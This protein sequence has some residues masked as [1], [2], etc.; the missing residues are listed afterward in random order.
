MGARKFS[1]VTECFSKF[2]TRFHLNKKNKR[3]IN[4]AFSDGFTVVNFAFIL[5]PLLLQQTRLAFTLHGKMRKA[6][7]HKF[8]TLAVLEPPRGPLDLP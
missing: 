1:K 2:M 4:H 5:P 8:L 7:S 6:G 3:A